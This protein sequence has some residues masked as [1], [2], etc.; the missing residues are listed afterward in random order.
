MYS[1]T[2]VI[3][4]IL[5]SLTSFHV[6]T[7][8]TATSWEFKTMLDASLFNGQQPCASTGGVMTYLSNLQDDLWTM[9][10]TGNCAVSTKKADDKHGHFAL[11]KAR[12]VKMYDS[13]ACTLYHDNYIFRV[14]RD[15]N[16]A[17]DD[18]WEGTLKARTDSETAT[19]ALRPNV[20]R[21]CTKDECDNPDIMGT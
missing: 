7:S 18:P 14:R 20:N 3:A 6:V 5:L 2:A 21:C 15:V 11:A 8:D 9:A 4:L 17:S 12:T 13:T 19:D 16:A 1:Q 10:T